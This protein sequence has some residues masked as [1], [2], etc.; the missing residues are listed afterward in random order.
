LKET[1]ISS[2]YSRYYLSMKGD[3]ED[4]KRLVYTSNQPVVINVYENRGLE[5]NLSI[6]RFAEMNNDVFKLITV[7][8]SQA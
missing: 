3:V 5:S 7:H 8:S 2:D 6:R 4:I 1:N